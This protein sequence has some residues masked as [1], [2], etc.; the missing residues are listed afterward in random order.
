M[1]E[2]PTASQWMTLLELASPLLVILCAALAALLHSAFL[3]EEESFFSAYL[4]LAALAA[5]FLLAWR[6]WPCAHG[7][8]IALMA[9]DRLSILSWMIVAVAGIFSAA[10]SLSWIG[11]TS[12]ARGEGATPAIRR[13][14]YFSLL[15]FSCFGMGVLVAAG[16]LVAVLVGLETMSLA[17]YALVGS[18]RGRAASLEGALKYFLMGAFATAFFAMGIAFIIGSAGSTDL[19]VL[20]ERASDIV[21]GEGRAFFLFGCAMALI[22]FAF[23][24]AA[25][26]FHSWAPDA[27][28]GAPTPVSSLMATGVKAAA[29]VALARFAFSAAAHAGGIWSGVVFG[30]AVATMVVGN[31][32]AIMQDNLKRMLAYSSIAHAGYLLV[33]FP[34]MLVYP[35]SSLRAVLLYLVAYVLMT[36]G[37]FAAVC[38]IEGMTGRVDV[39]GIQGMGRRRPWL[40]AA[41]T[42]FLL[43]LAGFPPTLGFFAKYYLF[44]SAV[45]GGDAA[46]VV[47]ALL[48][49]VV[50]IYYYLR[51]VVVM[52]FHDE[53]G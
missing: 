34:S 8:R 31:L 40:S 41:F 50:S 29:V 28:D 39:Q 3:E 33:A 20:S 38:A 27:Y 52:Y 13:G 30:L 7:E 44:L 46:L 45:R 23:K 6:V 15:L 37:A 26:P 49:S 21:A 43:S 4:A 2:A 32:A 24:V 51:P 10:T 53:K 18:A 36:A 12:P 42:L 22:G 19:A 17:A 9:I 48:A 11:K 47:V 35:A 16:D 5:S 25:V 14:E 1:F